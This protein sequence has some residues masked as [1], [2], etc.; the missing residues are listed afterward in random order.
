MVILT[1]GTITLIRVNYILKVQTDMMNT[2]TQMETETLLVDELESDA[3]RGD[4]R[5]TRSLGEFTITHYCACSICCGDSADGITATG[6][7]VTEGRT[8][9][10]DPEVI[11]LGSTVWISGHPYIAEDVGG[12]IEDKHIDI[13]VA[14][15]QEALQLGRQTK[16]VYQ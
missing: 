1:I 15:H 5:P 9:A 14:D 2:L 8:I 13:Y 3:S 16:E 11:A 10:V 4:L 7:Q 6:T 12:A